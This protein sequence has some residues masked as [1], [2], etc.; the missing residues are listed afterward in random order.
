[1]MAKQKPLPAAA[2]RTIRQLAAAF[3][4]ADIE[5]NLM[6]KFVEEKTGKPYNRDA[7]D[8]YLNMFLNSDP[9]TRRVW[10]LLQKDIVATRKSFAD[11]IA[12]ERA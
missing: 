9:E 3:V 6:A 1:M 10:Q 8:S 7:P 12:K 5:A 4:C 11:R 2:R